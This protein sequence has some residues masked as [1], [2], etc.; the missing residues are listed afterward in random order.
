MLPGALR[1]PFD[2]YQ[3]YRVVAD[4]VASLRGEGSEASVLDVGGRSAALRG[5]LSGPRVTLVDLEAAEVPGLVLGDGARLPFRDKCFDVVTSLD[6]LEHVPAPA[7][8]AFIRECGRVARRWVVLAGPYHSE[9]VAQAE[10]ILRRFMK[11]KLG[12]EH[13]FL[14]EHHRNGLPSREVT[15]R[16]LAALGARVHSVPH[17]N[18]E[19]WLAMMCLSMYLDDD[20]A[21][22]GIAASVHEFYNRT[23][24]DTDYAEPVYRHIVV[25][26]FDGAALPNGRVLQNGHAA[27][28]GALRCFG[29]LT[30]GLVA[31][32]RERAAWREERAKLAQVTHD[33]ATDLESHRDTLAEVERHLSSERAEAGKLLVHLEECRF[34]Q[35]HLLDE[36]EKQRGES[37]G[38]IKSLSADLDAHDRT[39]AEL[40]AELAEVRAEL[41]HRST[42][43]EQERTAST[44]TIAELEQDLAE[45]RT[46]RQTL[47]GEL[48]DAQR[49][50]REIE[51]ALRTEL[52]EHKRALASVSGDL[53][54]HHATLESLRALREQELGDA[55]A[56]RELF[57]RELGEH[58]RLQSELEAQ[59]AS[60]QA[61]ARKIQEELV[62][63]NESG[64]A[65]AR[66]LVAQE[67]RIAELNA[68]L[69]SRWKNLRRVFGRKRSSY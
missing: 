22:R 50:A 27:P 11:Q 2:M 8:T 5:F 19:R 52:A 18:L 64:A 55:L 60:G 28:R 59:L 56:A 61:D 46:T 51:S 47:E 65:A 17:A 24:Y 42:Q 48:E 29:E 39:I 49:G 1:L 37:A 20:P 9:R 3:R 15:E 54:L 58:Q 69:R 44:T 12:V 40:R 53:D 21:L 34:E 16:E 32:D 45:H 13:R 23:L 26:A 66:S 43:F 38:A 33:L 10:A 14:E 36:L 57:A 7:R 68:L 30:A 4:L 63:A 41:E 35:R 6:T 25:G 31:F 67:Q 62:R